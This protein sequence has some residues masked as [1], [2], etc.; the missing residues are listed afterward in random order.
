MV[1]PAV[2]TAYRIIEQKWNQWQT[3]S[4]SIYGRLN[5]VTK[6]IQEIEIGKDISNYTSMTYDAYVQAVVT[7]HNSAQLNITTKSPQSPLF[8][9]PLIRKL[10]G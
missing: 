9:T 5:T 2:L 8:P 3:E 4:N 7:Q 6:V 1:F 10:A